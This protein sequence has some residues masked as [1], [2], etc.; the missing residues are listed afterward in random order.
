MDI[1]SALFQFP[2]PL[3]LLSG[4]SNSLLRNQRETVPDQIL[5]VLFDD[6]LRF[7]NTFHTVYDLF[8]GVFKM[9][10]GHAFIALNIC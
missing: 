4:I 7:Q 3:F 10:S 5:R 6:A 1:V 2:V 9:L 8:P